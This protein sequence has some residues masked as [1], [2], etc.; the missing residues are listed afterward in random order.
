MRPRPRAPA[1][2]ALAPR[3]PLAPLTPAPPAAAAPRSPRANV[4]SSTFDP[5]HNPNV[6]TG[7]FFDKPVDGK[8]VWDAHLESQTAEPPGAGAGAGGAP[9]AP[10]RLAPDEVRRALAPE[11]VAAARAAA[12]RE[13]GVDR[14]A[15]LKMLGL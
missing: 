3:P 13:G 7:G 1:P 6:H 12:E 4:W 10:R 2:R 5:G 14:E 8:S 15:L 9:A 11:R